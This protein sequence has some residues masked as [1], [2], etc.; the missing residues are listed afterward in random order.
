M[1]LHALNPSP[2]VRPPFAST[3]ELY[4]QRSD[5]HLDVQSL[6]LS[7]ITSSGHIPGSGI[8]GSQDV[9]VFYGRETCCQIAL[10]KADTSLLCVSLIMVSTVLD[11]VTP[12]FRMTLGG[13][14]FGLS[15]SF[16]R[17]L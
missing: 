7:W 4:K 9:D 1:L 2:I 17:C 8:T 12:G 13:R 14:G 6:S 15:L 5:E 16:E 11:H 10:Q 3:L